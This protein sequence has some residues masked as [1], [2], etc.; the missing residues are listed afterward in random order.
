V[1][2]RA[3]SKDRA[4]FFFGC[5]PPRGSATAAARETR[6]DVLEAAATV[7]AG[8]LREDRK[9]RTATTAAA[10]TVTVTAAAP[11]TA[12]T[13][14]TAA[15]A[16]TITVASAATTRALATAAPATAFTF[17][18]ASA[19]LVLLVVTVMMVVVITVVIVVVVVMM[20]LVRHARI[21][22][23]PSTAVEFLEV[24]AICHRTVTLWTKAARPPLEHQRKKF[25]RL[26]GR[27]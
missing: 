9:W 23:R 13:V 20:M 2:A 21:V 26:F 5:P 8:D 19:L 17:A 25:A 15:P 7:R 3:R 18:L 27:C 11:A 14:T 24:M 22:T 10:I 12:V 4:L 1:A 16:A 6:E